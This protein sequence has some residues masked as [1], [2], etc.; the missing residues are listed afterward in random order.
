MKRALLGIGLLFV[1]CHDFAKAYDDCVSRGACFPEGSGGGGTTG[2]AQLDV[3]PHTLDFDVVQT[4]MTS[5]AQTFTVS[6][7]GPDASGAIS[8]SISGAAYMLSD[9]T[10]SNHTLA[11]GATCTF[12]ITF[13]P[14]MAGQAGGSVSASASPGGTAVATLT[15]NGVVPGTL[16]AMPSPHDFGSAIVGMMG[17]AYTFTVTSSVATGMLTAAIAGTDKSSFTIVQTADN[18]T[19]AMLGVGGQCTIDVRFDPQV[20]GSLLASLRVSDGTVS[21]AFASLTGVGLDSGAL[22]IN[23]MSQSFGSALKGTDGPVRTFTLSNSGAGNIG[24]L[25][26]TVTGT[27]KADFLVQDGGTCDKTTLS[28]DA[29]CS[30]S[31]LFHPT[32]NGME[33]ASLSVTGMGGAASAILSGTSLAPVSL[34][35]SPTTYDY[36]MVVEGDTSGFTFRFTNAGGVTSQ[37]L[38]AGAS[39]AAFSTTNDN[40]TGITLDAGASC[41]VDVTFAPNDAGTLS[42]ALLVG[43]PSTMIPLKGEGLAPGSITISGSLAF[44]PVAVGSSATKQLTV[45]NNGG[46]MTG[47]LMPQISGANASEVSFVPDTCTGA[48]LAGGA[49]CTLTVKFSPTVAGAKAASVAVSATPGGGDS[50]QLTGTGTAALTV[51]P[52]GTG[53]GTVTSMPSGIS[54]GA[55]CMATMSASPVTLTET[56]N[57]DSTFTSWAGCDSTPMPNTCQ[58]SMTG[59]RNVTA[60]FT[61]KQPVLSVG[62][63]VGSTGQGTITSSPAGID[64]GATCSHAYTYNTMVSLTATPDAGSIFSGW[65]GACSGMSCQVAMTSALSVQAQFTLAQTLTIV[66]ADGGMPAAAVS[67]TNGQV[68]CM[69]GSYPCTYYFPANTSLS[70]GVTPTTGNLFAGW[71]GTD[72]AGGSHHCNVTLSHPVTVTVATAPVTNNVVFFSSFQFPAAFGG[73]PF[74][75]NTCNNLATDAGVNNAAGNAFIAYVSATGN[76]ATTRLGS[77]RGWQRMDGRPF[78]DDLTSLLAGKVLYP[79]LF[80]DTGTEPQMYKMGFWT[81]TMPAGTLGSTCTNWTSSAGTDYGTCGGGGFGPSSWSSLNCNCDP[82]QYQMGFLCMGKTLT[83]PVTIVPTA[84]KKI[85]VTNTIWQPGGGPAGADSKCMSERPTGVTTAKAVIGA[86]APA[87]TAASTLNPATVYVRVDGTFVGTGADILASKAT[88]GVW[89][90]ANGT[91]TNAT[92]WSGLPFYDATMPP[93]DTNTTCNDWGSAQGTVYGQAADTGTA[94]LEAQWWSSGGQNPCNA[95]YERVLCAEQ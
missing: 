13:A 23:P 48:Q 46:A 83:N 20:S 15:G 52:A 10:C 65:S 4:G 37:V 91:Y 22:V 89:Q 87:R 55:T 16:T 39:G 76:L 33:Q 49:N 12:A 66:G 44:S 71:G 81:G 26:V 28:P 78:A 21:Q 59:V 95:M 34:T 47:M 68:H 6:N 25:A 53:T 57:V 3:M 69:P 62:T 90:L 64:C 2:Q 17:T 19:G 31:V 85:Y 61:Q 63:A 88:N 86:V 43:P 42:G 77:A 40:C 32:G 36:G 70:L 29:G 75:D 92:V 27:S 56:P 35:P 72:C 94:I 14:T 54:C 93:T 82:N 58:V 30:V 73:V 60:T 84:G 80:D 24:P 5:A 74:A 1:S 18:C 41:T 11:S 38:T 51:T 67:S 50:V 9:D 7:A 45:F 8:L 79:V